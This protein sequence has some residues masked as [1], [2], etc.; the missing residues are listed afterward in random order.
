MTRRHQLTFELETLSIIAISACLGIV[1][2]MYFHNHPKK[3]SFPVMDT[4]LSPTP[5]APPPP[6]VDSSSQTSPDGTKKLTM[7]ITS[8]N[9]ADTKSY[10]FT[11][12][13][14]D[15]SN[16]Q[17]IYTAILPPTE[18]LTIPFNTWSPDNKYIFLQH[19]TKEGNEALVLRANGE[20]MTE[21]D[22][23]FNAATLFAA[24]GTPYTYQ[25][26]T[27]WASETLLIFNTTNA[28]GTKGPSYWLEVPSKAVIQLSTEF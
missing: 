22:Q 15:G 11:T 26:T 1:L 17:Q 9:D 23:S 25:E 28:D 27:G 2:A 19:N 4:Q 8:K 16:Q 12:T 3:I 24:R 14:A 7:T 5:T 21:T 20:P 6:Q 13:D 18:S 10:I